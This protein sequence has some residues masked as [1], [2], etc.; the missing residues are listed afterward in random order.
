MMCLPLTTFC[1]ESRSCLGGLIRMLLLHGSRVLSFFAD[2]AMPRTSAG[3][4]EVT[5]RS[6]AHIGAVAR[7]KRV[8][9]ACLCLV[10]GLATWPSSQIPSKM[11]T[12]CETPIKTDV[13][14]LR[15]TITK[16]L[17]W[18]WIGGYQ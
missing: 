2:L 13:N 15:M 4:T 8:C 11:H 17:Y 18:L 7:A 9:A 1:G 14:M 5:E 12:Y 10:V 3:R 6:E 16:L